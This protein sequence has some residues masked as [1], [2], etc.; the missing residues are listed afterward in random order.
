[1]VVILLIL[2]SICFF[3]T[4]LVSDSLSV[5]QAVLFLTFPGFLFLLYLVVR[6]NSRPFKLPLQSW[7]LFSCGMVLFATIFSKVSFIEPLMVINHT[8]FFAYAVV[9]CLAYNIA[10]HSKLTLHE[11]RAALYVL[12]ILLLMF[13]LLHI[14]SPESFVVKIQTPRAAIDYTGFRIGG[15]L[16]WSYIFAFVI[17]PVLLMALH[18]TFRGEAGLLGV[19]VGFSLLMIVALSQSKSAYLATFTALFLYACF[20]LL[21]YRSNKLLLISMAISLVAITYLL[22]AFSEQFAHIWGFIESV[23]SGQSDAS[24]KARLNQISLISLTIDNALLT[25]YPVIYENIENGYAHYLYFYGVIGLTTYLVFM[26]AFWLDSYYRCKL[27]FA[28]QNGLKIGLPIGMLAFTTVAPIYALS[29]SPIDSHK[30]AY[31]F[32]SVMALYGGLFDKHHKEKSH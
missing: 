5:S 19:L 13:T 18:E 23:E 4:Y 11:L 9:Y 32:F 7:L 31:F 14:V 27:S 25:G 28:K 20:S 3:P 30:G 2:L 16:E 24:T 26:A 29:A 6:D 12:V 21:N 10:L 22:F 1:M 15:P 8:R 17:T